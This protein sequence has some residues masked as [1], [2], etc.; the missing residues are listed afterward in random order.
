MNSEQT[1]VFPAKHDFS[2]RSKA[3][4]PVQNGKWHQRPSNHLVNIYKLIRGKKK[5]FDRRRPI[6]SGVYAMS[7]TL[8]TVSL[9]RIQTLRQ[10]DREGSKQGCTGNEITKSLRDGYKIRGNN[11][12]EGLP[13]SCTTAL[14][15]THPQSL[16]EEFCIL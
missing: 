11:Q 5:S 4:N 10:T 13:E 15:Y 7:L 8:T 1:G 9:H 14:S 6:Q 12:T 3:E 16:A 2:A